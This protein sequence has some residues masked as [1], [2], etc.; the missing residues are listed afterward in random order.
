MGPWKAGAS[1]AL[2]EV[3]P[4]LGAQLCAAGSPRGRTW[5]SQAETR[6]NVGMGSAPRPAPPQGF[7]SGRVAWRKP[8]R[9]S[10]AQG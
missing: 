8:R 2:G 3:P 7:L 10:Q 6:A 9:R 4:K 1:E 5:A